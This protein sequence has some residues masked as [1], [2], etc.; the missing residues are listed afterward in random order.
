MNKKIYVVLEKIEDEFHIFEMPIVI[1]DNNP[2]IK[3]VSPIYR[4]AEDFAKNLFSAVLCEY[5]IINGQLV[6]GI[7]LKTFE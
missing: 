6:N 1:H 3:L 4:K 7:I 5:E 2:F